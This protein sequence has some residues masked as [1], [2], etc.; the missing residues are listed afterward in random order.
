MLVCDE[1][2]GP[3]YFSQ[4]AKPID[5]KPQVHCVNKICQLG[6]P[7]EGKI[8]RGRGTIKLADKTRDRSHSLGLTVFGFGCGLESAPCW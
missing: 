6:E 7:L 5:T 8:C 4:R 3:N 1:Y 2:P